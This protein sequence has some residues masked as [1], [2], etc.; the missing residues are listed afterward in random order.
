MQGD[1]QVFQ[2]SEEQLVVLNAFI[3]ALPLPP[4]LANANRANY[5]L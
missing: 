1:K 2:F 5:N 3:L 4:L